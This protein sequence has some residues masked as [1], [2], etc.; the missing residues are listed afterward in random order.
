MSLAG[1][2]PADREVI[3]APILFAMVYITERLSWKL[4]LLAQLFSSA[5]RI[6]I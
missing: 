3:L 4:R 6:L 2:Y 1:D 5:V